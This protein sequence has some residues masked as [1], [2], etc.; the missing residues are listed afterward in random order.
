M[1]NNQDRT[2]QMQRKQELEERLAKIRKD[3]TGGLNPDFEEQAVQ[4]E[5]R[6]SHQSATTTDDRVTC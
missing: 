6:E 3:M 4:L 1:S 5:N 2:E